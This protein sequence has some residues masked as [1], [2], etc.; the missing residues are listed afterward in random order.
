MAV[1]KQAREVHHEPA[2]SARVA[3]GLHLEGLSARS[4]VPVPELL[5]APCIWIL[6]GPQ[7]CQCAVLVGQGSGT[8]LSEKILPGSDLLQVWPL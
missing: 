8:E 7:M 3:A 4:S 5:P 6:T 2:G 1:L